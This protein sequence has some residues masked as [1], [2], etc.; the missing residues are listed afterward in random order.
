MTKL[1]AALEA[2]QPPDFLFG[3]DAT[4]VAAQWAYEDRLV[5]L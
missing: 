5:D 3:T 2:G 1:E 4:A